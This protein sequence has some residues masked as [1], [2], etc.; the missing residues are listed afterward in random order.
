MKSNMKDIT[1][2]KEP[3]GNPKGPLS[4]SK[5]DPTGKGGSKSEGPITAGDKKVMFPVPGPKDCG[6]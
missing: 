5:Y 3:M 2:P 1:T 6:E 4:S